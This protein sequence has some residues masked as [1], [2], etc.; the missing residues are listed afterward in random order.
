MQLKPDQLDAHLAR[1]LRPIYTL[2]GD[3]PLLVQEAAD[4]LRT[5]ARAAGYGER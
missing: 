4:A 1:G 2:H 3:E 5:A